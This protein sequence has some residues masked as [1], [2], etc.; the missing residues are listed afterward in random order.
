MLLY[1]HQKTINMQTVKIN[2]IK[3]VLA[4]ENKTNK[5]LAE[6]LNRNE[7]TVSRWCTNQVQPPMDTFL[8]ISEILDVDIRDLLCSKKDTRV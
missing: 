8:K 2:R 3:A 5:W 1:L 6:Q 4:E 7:T